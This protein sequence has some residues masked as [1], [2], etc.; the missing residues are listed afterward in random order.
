LAAQ[1][2][3]EVFDQLVSLLRRELTKI[4]VHT[5]PCIACHRHGM[6]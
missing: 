1:E 2:H 4:F 6:P 3:Q 5:L